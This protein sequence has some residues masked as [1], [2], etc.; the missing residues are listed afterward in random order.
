MVVTDV[1]VHLWEPETPECVEHFSRGL[2]FLP[3]SDKDWV[4]GK[5]PAEVLK[6][7]EPR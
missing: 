5:A 3:A 6:W 7:P 1:K 2:A 4:L